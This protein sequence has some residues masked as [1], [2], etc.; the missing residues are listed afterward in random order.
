V[1]IM[2]LFGLI[3]SY[4]FAPTVPYLFLGF[5]MTLLIML[6]V[7]HQIDLEV[8]LPFRV[9]GRY[10][11]LAGFVATALASGIAFL[12]WLTLGNRISGLVIGLPFRT[13]AARSSTPA[14]PALQVGAGPVTLSDVEVL[15]VR[16]LRGNAR[17]LRMD[18]YDFYTGR[19]WNRTRMGFLRI[20]ANAR[21]EF[22]IP[23]LP[24]YAHLRQV[25]A[26]ITV[27]GGVHLQFYTPGIPV[28]LKPSEP[29]TAV[30]FA[31]HA[32]VIWV[33][34]PLAPGSQYEVRAMVPTQNPTILRGRDAVTP[35]WIAW[36]ESAR[37]PRVFELVRQLTMNQPTDY[38]KVIALKHYIETRAAYNIET[39][40]YPPDEDA[41]EYFLFVARQGYCTE[42]ASALAV[43]C[44]YAGLSARVASGFL[45]TERDPQTGEYIVRERHRH[46]WT[47]VYF[48]G[49]GWVPFDATEGARVINAGRSP[50]SNADHDPSRAHPLLRWQRLLDGLI[51][52]GVIYLLWSLGL[53]RRLLRHAGIPT[54]AGRLY[55]RLV[56]FLRLIGCPQPY[57]Y[58]SPVDY[59]SNCAAM[60]R[61]GGHASGA[62][63]V[64]ALKEPLARLLYAPESASVE[65]DAQGKIK[66]LRLWMWQEIGVLRLIGRAVALKGR[67]WFELSNQQNHGGQIR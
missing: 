60:L 52:A 9:I 8:Q 19:G 27:M 34:R 51:L 4:L 25:H 59:L 64:E 49:L 5:V 17:Y 18:A 1:P 20:E 44:Q 16:F 10:A 46:L 15:R 55:A 26:Q 21:G 3:G 36:S 31:P 47:E 30:G 41:V 56:W 48:D 61:A 23:E 65:A 2:A 24:N 7:A 58:Q 6:T 29:R 37:N 43:M 39:E 14:L 66:A 62:S 35:F 54:R 67:D 22:I 53:A 38:D 33:R 42:F 28:W 13:T 63:L 32:G 57:P 11:L 45:L 50:N 12:L 40:A